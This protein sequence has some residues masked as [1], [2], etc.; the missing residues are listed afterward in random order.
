M[1]SFFQRCPYFSVENLSGTNLW[2][3]NIRLSFF[4]NFRLVEATMDTAILVSG[5]PPPLAKGV[6]LCDCPQ[7][8]NASS[9]QDPS[10]GFYRYYN[11]RTL[12]TIPVDGT[13]IIDISGDDV[14]GIIGDVIPCNCNDRSKTCDIETGHCTVSKP[15]KFYSP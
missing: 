1:D 8:Y 4:S 10:I 15:L 6:E 12:N 5:Q 9:C 11:N 14:T 13:I 2:G 7:Q 3:E